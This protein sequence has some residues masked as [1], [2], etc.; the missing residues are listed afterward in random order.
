MRVV[1][2]LGDVLLISSGPGEWAVG[3]AIPDGA[4]VWTQATAAG[5]R[6][7]EDRREL[8]RVVEREYRAR[9][10]GGLYVAP[11]GE[12]VRL[13]QAEDGLPDRVHL[14]PLA[15]SE[16]ALLFVERVV[17]MGGTDEGMLVAGVAPDG[18]A[19]VRY[20]RSG[21]LGGALAQVRRGRPEVV[22][23]HPG[24]VEVVRGGGVFGARVHS[25]EDRPVLA[26]VLE[27]CADD[28]LA[29][30]APVWVEQ[31][32]ARLKRS[33]GGLAVLGVAALAVWGAWAVLGVMASGDV[34]RAQRVHGEA[35]RLRASLEGMGRDELEV[36]LATT[37]DWTRA[38]EDLARALGDVRLEELHG[39]VEL[40]DRV[41]L[42]GLAVPLDGHVR[43]GRLPGLSAR[44]VLKG[45]R[46]AIR[47][48]YEV[49]R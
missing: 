45:G 28:A 46:V 6:S 10:G 19:R 42:E 4:Q 14:L 15:S 5:E 30:A 35:E 39:R 1:M 49:K 8:I 23:V 3:S 32:R 21:V 31:E 11:S 9:S 13:F 20:L 17:G 48:R 24:L 37:P 47:F 43:V 41:M 27:G 7:G 33:A 2:A 29:V 38:L 44:P 26:R 22:G 40:G 18:G 34:E 36:R 25:G 16:S 12:G